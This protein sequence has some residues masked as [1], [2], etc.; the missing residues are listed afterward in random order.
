MSTVTTAAET[1]QVKGQIEL[2]DPASI[3]A[4]PYA[5]P[6]LVPVPLSKRTWTTYNFVVVGLGAGFVVYLVLS[7]PVFGKTGDTPASEPDLT[8]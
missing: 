6:E 1:R 8:D 7:L 3:A 2:T 5:N 4:S